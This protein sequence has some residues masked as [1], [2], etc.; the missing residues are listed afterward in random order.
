M[1]KKLGL[2]QR[3]T[4]IEP[5]QEQRDSLDKRWW[6]MVDALN[7]VPVPLAT[8]SAEQA[9]SYA[10]ALGLSGIILTGGGVDPARDAFEQALIAW[11]IKQ[12]LPIVGV[13]RGMQMINRYFGGTLV[14]IST[15]RATQHHV[16]FC[17]T[18]ENLNPRVVNSYHDFG[19]FPAQ[20]AAPLRATAL[21]EDGSIEALIHPDYKIA[22]LMWHPEREATLIN[23]DIELLKG[24]LL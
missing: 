18:W 2:T 5:Y 19:I 7:A 4:R 20:L 1:I 24:L 12:D 3:I 6:D 8:L 13:C 23:A 16:T 17:H 14:P 11:A 10:E 21:H 9:A 15:H 22:G